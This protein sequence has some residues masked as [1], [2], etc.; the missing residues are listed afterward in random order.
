MATMRGH[1]SPPA[2]TPARA[3]SRGEPAVVI[4]FAEGAEG[5][6]LLLDLARAL[7]RRAARQYLV[8][9]T[10]TDPA[11]NPDAGSCDG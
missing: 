2:S 7:A 1:P 6:R 5:D 9:T 3:A 11:A 10:D 8:T 4:Q